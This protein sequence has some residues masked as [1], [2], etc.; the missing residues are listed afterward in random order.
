MPMFL[1]T[2]VSVKPDWLSAFIK[3]SVIT[4]MAAI[5]HPIL[6]NSDVAWLKDDFAA[7]YT[8][9]AIELYWRVNS[10][11]LGKISLIMLKLFRRIRNELHHC[12]SVH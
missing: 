10:K 5:S 4:I 9:S 2:C 12:S 6:D 11:N 1:A 3:L 8:K 7:L